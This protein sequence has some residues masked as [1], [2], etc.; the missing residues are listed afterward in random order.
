MFKVAIVAALEREVRP[1]VR[2]WRPSEKEYGDRR[3]RFFED[4]ETVLVCGG[5]G[6]EAARRAAEAV[7]AIYAQTVVCSAGFAG[8]LDP[9][10]KVGTVM[11]PAQVIDTR[12][13]SRVSVSGGMG[14]LVSFGSVA[15]PVQKAKL[16]ESYGAQ[17]V[18]MEASAVARTAQVRGLE[19]S[20][21]K[22]I[23]DEVDFEFP[24][25]ER[26]VDSSGNFQQG[27]FAVYAALRPW[28]WLKMCTLAFNSN[29]ASRCLCEWL[30]ALLNPITNCVPEQN[31]E[32]N[33][34]AMH[35][36]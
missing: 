2:T 4:G 28:L 6:A 23:S 1:L 5:I 12:D 24:A 33:V 34:E 3:F 18:D 15:S 10:L 26:F 30:E 35:R 14:V 22:A 16:R 29:L 13:G 21:V 8:A 20:A 11:Q 17:I 9:A 7:I 32:Q 31:S 19:F 25:T 36:R 27:R